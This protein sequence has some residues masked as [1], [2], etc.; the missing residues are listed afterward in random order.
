MLEVTKNYGV[1][2]QI[3]NK[4]NIKISQ[5]SLSPRRAWEIKTDKGLSIALGRVDMQARLSKFA[6][7]Y[8]STLSQINAKIVYADLR[9]PNGFAVRKPIALTKPAGNKIETGKQASGKSVPGKAELGKPLEMTKKL[10]KPSAINQ[11]PASLIKLANI[12]DG[13]CA[14]V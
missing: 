5:V 10:I 4:T 9:Y 11:I 12:T 3:L 6:G 13:Q 14:V 2:S 8:Q 7:A 1:Y